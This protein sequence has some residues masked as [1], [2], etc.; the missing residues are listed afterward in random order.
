MNRFECEVRRNLAEALFARLQLPI[1]KFGERYPHQVSGGQLQRAATAMALCTRPRLVVFD[2]PTTALDVTVQ[3]EVLSL[4]RDVIRTEGLSAIYISHDLAVV[5]QVADEIVVLRNGAIVEKG[6]AAEIIESPKQE[7]T[8]KLLS[9]QL[10]KRLCQNYGTAPIAEVRGVSAGYG[11]VDI[12]RNVS[13]QL[14]QGRT[15]A[16]VGES[17]SGKSSVAR[18]ILGLLPSRQGG[19]VYCGAPLSRELKQRELQVRQDLQFI[20]QN[21]D[22]ALNPRQT[23]EKILSRPLK[24]YTDLRGKEL[25]KRLVAVME[26]ME[27]NSSLLSRMP[28]ELSGGQKQRVCIA[29]AL[30][31]TPKVIICDEVTSALDPLVADGI[32]KE[33]GWLDQFISEHRAAVRPMLELDA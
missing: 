13:F 21:P 3:V 1:E 32:V 22:I 6:P 4:I 12:V 2:E 17:G 30:C 26:Q 24:L 28:A 5:A 8:N 29:R 9:V 11:S 7:Y 16:V 27:L 15:L 31:A 23:I 18:V 10:E 33:I 19:V 25:R 20:Y 14:N